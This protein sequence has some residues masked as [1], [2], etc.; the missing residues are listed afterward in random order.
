MAR[1]SI[2]AAVLPLLVPLATGAATH[3][4]RSSHEGLAKR[5]PEAIKA[6]NVSDADD[7]VFDDDWETPTREADLPAGVNDFEDVSDD[8]WLAK[9]LS[10]NEDD[11]IVGPKLNTR[12]KYKKA[13]I[14]W[15][16]AI[17]SALQHLQGTNVFGMYTWSPWCPPQAKQYGIRCFPMFWGKKSISQWKQYVKKGYS[18]HALGM[19]ECNQAG[20]SQLSPGAAA[21]LWR[22]YVAPMKSKGYTLVSPSTSNAKT[23]L[24]WY[25]SYFKTCPDCHTGKVAAHFYGTDPNHFISYIESVHA[26]TGNST[27]W[28]TEVACQDFS[29]RTNCNKN[30]AEKFMTAIMNWMDKTSWVEMYAYFGFFAQARAGVSSANALLNPSGTL[31]AMGKKYVYS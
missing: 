19:N 21:A 11:G 23:S 20:E 5:L 2:L 3:N 16:N 10:E 18:D 13:A 9:L 24:S 1:F 26:A 14:P 4:A 22:K 12:T 28:V 17:P 7:W 25:Q 31:N 30:D 27:I 8:E 15:P 6:R 29:G